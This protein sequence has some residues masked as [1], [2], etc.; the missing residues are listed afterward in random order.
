MSSSGAID[1]KLRYSNLAWGYSFSYPA[2]TSFE[3]PTFG[4]MPPIEISAAQTLIVRA[5]QLSSVELVAVR[6]THNPSSDEIT[7]KFLAANAAYAGV[8]VPPNPRSSSMAVAAFRVNGGF[9]VGGYLCGSDPY[10]N[11]DTL[12]NSPGGTMVNIIVIHQ[13]EILCTITDSDATNEIIDSI[14]ANP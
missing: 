4:D 9:S 8:S 5:P 2:G 7:T 10:V 13:D 1:T 3:S 14:I 12:P 6:C 11:S